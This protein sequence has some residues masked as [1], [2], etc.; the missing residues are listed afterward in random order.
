MT[1][2]PFLIRSNMMC[3]ACVLQTTQA[4]PKALATANA[5]TNEQPLSTVQP[6]S[7]VQANAPPVAAASTAA[8]GAD[9]SSS[10][11]FSLTGN[12]SKL[13]VFA[14]VGGVVAALA[15]LA[16]CSQVAVRAKR[17]NNKGPATK[18]P[19]GEE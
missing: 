7:L 4:M 16:V 18:F 8:A 6:S 5:A 2:P 17:R 19:D 13:V 3:I 10:A 9:K 15:L 12:S 11:T 1:A 14:T